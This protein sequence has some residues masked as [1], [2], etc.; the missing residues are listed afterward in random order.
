MTYYQVTMRHNEETFQLLAHMQYDLF[1]K[2]NRISRSVLSVVLILIGVFNTDYWWSYLL[3]GYG[4]YLTSSTYSAANHTANKLSRGIHAAKMKFP[5]SRY[6]FTDEGMVIYTLPEDKPFGEPLLYA[7]FFRLGEDRDYFYIFRNQHGGYMIPKSELGA[8]QEEFRYF[9]QRNTGKK[10]ERKLPPIA[11]L[12]QAI[13]NK[14]K[15][16]YHL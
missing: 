4:W 14:E 11:K 3:I 16:P 5:A 1:C 9:V 6:E 12:V 8:I 13:K 10:F 15:E 2:G 7:D